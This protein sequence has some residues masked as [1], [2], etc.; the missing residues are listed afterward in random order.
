MQRVR[1]IAIV[2][3]GTDDAPTEPLTRERWEPEGRPLEQQRKE[4]RDRATQMIDTA[5]GIPE[6]HKARMIAALRLLVTRCDSRGEVLMNLSTMAGRL[7]HAGHR[8]S[9]VTIRRALRDLEHYGYIEREAR[10]RPVGAQTG[11]LYRLRP[12]LDAVQTQSKST[13]NAC[14]LE[15]GGAVALG[16]RSVAADRGHHGRAVAIWRC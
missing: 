10:A 5:D 14:R 1:D 13:P 11:N 12:F 9:E 2:P 4:W 3:T 8:M 7:R 6:R 15:P 16:H